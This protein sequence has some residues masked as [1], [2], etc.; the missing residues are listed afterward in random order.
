MNGWWD[1]RADVRRRWSWSWM[2]LIEG[3]ESGSK[4][5]I[6]R[7][8]QRCKKEQRKEKETMMRSVLYSTVRSRIGCEW[9]ERSKG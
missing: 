5:G 7:D 6:L 4:A 3:A 9:R 8:N 2:K 1:A